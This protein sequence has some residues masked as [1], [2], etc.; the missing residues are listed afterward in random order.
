MRGDVSGRK[1]GMPYNTH[2][3]CTDAAYTEIVTF[4]SKLEY[5]GQRY[6]GNV[7]DFFATQ[8]LVENNIDKFV[9]F[10]R[11]SINSGFFQMQM[12]LLDSN[13]LIDA[14]KYP[15]KYKNLIVRVWGF[16][17]YFNELP[18]SYK[19]LLI[20]RALAAEKIAI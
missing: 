17:A 12:N 19:N 8:N 11:G 18:E 7:I 16:S 20:E 2:I 14:K 5:G 10:I 13:T 1:Y 6:N 9:L 3:S 4:A 15:E